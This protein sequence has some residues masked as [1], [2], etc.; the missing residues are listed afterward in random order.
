MAAVRGDAVINYLATHTPAECAARIL[1]L[2][3]DE[4]WEAVAKALCI[5]TRRL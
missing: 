3:P 1:Q 4:R 2:T 5:L